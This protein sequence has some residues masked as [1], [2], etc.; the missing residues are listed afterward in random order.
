MNELI[1]QYIQNNPQIGAT[2]SGLLAAD[3]A[4]EPN[5]LILLKNP[6]FAPFIGEFKHNIHLN[7]AHI[8]RC[9]KLL[10]RKNL[11]A[12]IGSDKDAFNIFRDYARWD[13]D[14]TFGIAEEMLEDPITAEIVKSNPKLL[15]KTALNR[16]LD[17]TAIDNMMHF[18]P[19]LAALFVNLILNGNQPSGYVQKKNIA[20]RKGSLA[21]QFAHA[22]KRSQPY[23]N[24]VNQIYPLPDL[25]KEDSLKQYKEIGLKS[26]YFRAEEIKLDET[27]PL[28]IKK[29]AMEGGIREIVIFC[30]KAQ[31]NLSS[32]EFNTFLREHQ[33]AINLKIAP[34]S[35][36]DLEQ[37][38]KD[39]VAKNDLLG[40]NK[41][42]NFTFVYKD[43]HRVELLNSRESDA[44]IIANHL[45]YRRLSAEKYK[46]APPEPQYIREN[47]DESQERR[48][49]DPS[50]ASRHLSIGVEVQSS[51]TTDVDVDVDTSMEVALEHE[52]QHELELDKDELRNLYS[53]L[54]AIDEARYA[55]KE[56]FYDN[57]I[58]GD[59]TRS[60]MGLV[61]N[62]IFDSDD[63]IKYISGKALKF[64]IR[65]DHLFADG[66][67]PDNMPIGMT[68]HEGNLVMSAKRH[69]S[70]QINK[71]TI[72][73]DDEINPIISHPLQYSWLQFASK[74]SLS[75]AD[76]YMTDLAPF[77]LPFLSHPMLQNHRLLGQTDTML[78][79]PAVLNQVEYS[80]DQHMGDIHSSMKIPYSMKLED[81]GVNGISLSDAEQAT[82]TAIKYALT[83]RNF[84]KPFSFIL[85]GMPSNDRG[86]L[87]EEKTSLFF[88]KL[89]E[90]VLPLADKE[91][92]SF[93]RDI[94]GSNILS[95]TSLV[96][97]FEGLDGFYDKFQQFLIDQEIEGDDR[98]EIQSK[99]IQVI[100][101]QLYNI[102][103]FKTSLSRLYKILQ[104]TT[105]IGGSLQEQLSYLTS[106]DNRVSIGDPKI[107]PRATKIG[108]NV[109]NKYAKLSEVD[110]A[111]DLPDEK[112]FLRKLR[113]LHYS[114]TDPKQLEDALKESA[115]VL[116]AVPPQQRASIDGSFAYFKKIYISLP[117]A[118]VI[119]GNLL[120]DTERLGSSPFKTVDYVSQEKLDE[121][122]YDLIV[123]ADHNHW[124]LKALLSMSSKTYTE[125]PI[126]TSGI[127]GEGVNLIEHFTAKQAQENIKLLLLNTLS[128][129]GKH[130]QQIYPNQEFDSYL[131]L[132]SALFSDV[133]IHEKVKT[134]EIYYSAHKDFNRGV[135]YIKQNFS[136]ASIPKHITQKE[137]THKKTVDNFI[138]LYADNPEFNFG[139]VVALG[140]VKNLHPVKFK[141]VVA[142]AKILKQYPYHFGQALRVILSADAPQTSNKI[143]VLRHKGLSVARTMNFLLTEHNGIK[144]HELVTNGGHNPEN[145]VLFA[146]VFAE[147]QDITPEEIRTFIAK[148]DKLDESLKD[149]LLDGL[150]HSKLPFANS[151]FIQNRFPQISMDMLDDP[152]ALNNVITQAK[153]SRISYEYLAQFNDISLNVREN[154][155]IDLTGV[156]SKH[157]IKFPKEIEGKG[158]K[159]IKNYII[160]NQDFVKS[161]LLGNQ[162]DKE[163]IA[164]IS[165][166][167]VYA[168]FAGVAKRTEDWESITAKT[169][170]LLYDESKNLGEQFTTL[171]ANKH[172]IDALSRKTD[173]NNL[174]SSFLTEPKING[175]KLSATL[176]F[177][178]GLDAGALASK[179]IT[180]EGLVQAAGN[181]LINNYFDGFRVSVDIM[182]TSKNKIDIK[183]I[184]QKINNLTAHK[185]K[186]RHINK[187]MGYCIGNDN[188]KIADI[189][190]GLNVKE[191]NIDKVI[192]F[193]TGMSMS[194]MEK[195]SDSLGNNI[196][197]VM[198]LKDISKIPI[199]AEITIKLGDLI[200]KEQYGLMVKQ[201]EEND[202]ANAKLLKSYL[203]AFNPDDLNAQDEK[204]R[205][206]NRE[207]RKNII[208]TVFDNID[209][210][211]RAQVIFSEYNLER[212][213]YSDER[214]KKIINQV[215]RLNT[216]DRSPMPQNQQ[217]LMFD[218]F[219][220]AMSHAKNYSKMDVNEVEKEA[221]SLKH[222]R[223]LMNQ[224]R[225]DE[226]R[227]IDSKFLGLSLEM[228]YRNTSK[229]P[230]DVQITSVLTTMEHKGNVLQQIATGQGKGLISALSASYFSYLGKTPDV[231]TA[232]R[233]LARRDLKEFSQFYDSLAIKHCKKIITADSDVDE[234]KHGEVHV[235]VAS[236]LALFISNRDFHSQSANLAVQP[237]AV[238]IA[239]EFDFVA[240]SEVNFKLAMSLI[241][242]SQEEARVLLKH[243]LE[244]SES[245][246]F[247]NNKVS[248][249]DDVSNLRLYIN[250]RFQ[251]Y[252][253]A[254][255][256]PLTLLQVD[257]LK[258]S[259]D[260]EAQMLYLVNNALSKSDK[261]W[262]YMFDKLLDSAVSVKGLTKDVDFVL[263]EESLADT[264]KLITATPIIKNQPSRGTIYADGVQ[265]ILNM[266]EED[267]NNELKGRFDISLPQST[268]FDLTPK[269]F[270]DY[271]SRVLGI[272]GTAGNTEELEELR[273]TTKVTSYALPMF[274]EDKKIVV[275]Q[276]VE[277]KKL[278]TAHMLKLVKESESERPIITFCESPK[279]AEKLF[280]DIAGL[281]LNIQL[282]LPSA[283]KEEIER[284]VAVAGSAG[285]ITITTGMLGRG[286]DFFTQ[287]E[288]GF[289]GINL[290]TDITLN[291][292]GQIEGRVARNGH[293]GTVVSLF[294]KKQFG[295]DRIEHM[296]EISREQKRKREKSQPASDVA[297][298]M[299]KQLQDQEEEA[300]K[301]N[302]FIKDKWAELDVENRKLP[303]SMQRSYLELR[304]DLTELL[305]V[306]YPKLTGKLDEYLKELDA[307]V[308]KKTGEMTC[309]FKQ[310]W[311]ADYAVTNGWNY[312]L[313]LPTTPSVEVARFVAIS[314][315]P[316]PLTILEKPQY[317]RYIQ[318]NYAVMAGHVWGL[319]EKKIRLSSDASKTKSIFS[320]IA[321][322][323][324][325]GS[326]EDVIIIETEGSNGTLMAD[327]FKSSF[328]AY[329]KHEQSVEIDKINNIIGNMRDIEHSDLSKLEFGKFIALKITT[330]FSSEASHAELLLTDGN[331][332]LWANRGGDGE[333]GKPG[334][335]VFKIV[336]KDIE[337]IKRTLESLKKPQTQQLTRKLIYSNLLWS[338]DPKHIHIDMSAQRVGNCG[339]MQSKTLVRAAAIVGKIDTEAAQLPDEKDKKWLTALNY[340]NKIYRD[341]VQ[342]DKIQRLEAILFSKDEKFATEFL[343][344]DQKDEINKRRKFITEPI[345]PDLL[346]SLVKQLEREVTVG[347][348]ETTVYREQA[349][350]M[351]DILKVYEAME[352]KMGLALY[353]EI[354]KEKTRELLTQYQATH[355]KNFKDLEGVYDA[356]LEKA[357][358][359]GSPRSHAYVFNKV[360]GYL[361]KNTDQIN[362]IDEFIENLAETSKI[363][364]DHSLATKPLMQ[365][366]PLPENIVFPM[367]P[368]TDY[369]G[370]IDLG[371]INIYDSGLLGLNY[372]SSISAPDATTYIPTYTTNIAD[373]FQVPDAT[374]YIPTYT[375]NITDTFHLG[376]VLFHWSKQAVNQL[377]D[378]TI[379][380]FSEDI[381]AKVAL[382]KLKTFDQEHKYLHEALTTLND[383][384]T[385]LYARK[386]TIH[387]DKANTTVREEIDELKRFKDAIAK[388]KEDLRKVKSEIA[389]LV[390]LQQPTFKSVYI[391]RINSY[392]A[393][394]HE[395]H[396]AL[397]DDIA[398]SKEGYNCIVMDSKSAALSATLTKKDIAL[399]L[400]EGILM[401]K[402]K[403]G[404]PIKLNK[405]LVDITLY[406]KIVHHVNNPS[407]TS[408]SFVDDGNVGIAVALS[409]SL[410]FVVNERM[411]MREHLLRRVGIFTTKLDTSR[412]LSS[413][414][415]FCKS[416]N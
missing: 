79:L 346:R 290:C 23:I 70:M 268:I 119:D 292:L 214:V 160:C 150:A 51:T 414:S 163:K 135:V 172:F 153:S 328:D 278:Q 196:N 116:S 241:D 84:Y 376:R 327:E 14:K 341:F 177:L 334:I 304:G 392:M 87:F 404:A 124:K 365:V 250:Y 301:N 86:F 277:N 149:E 112:E 132:F 136:P 398:V 143:D 158:Y 137:E 284:K 37:I 218:S 89:F 283:P 221:I 151:K 193:L 309:E 155:A 347:S 371:Q 258:R 201:I 98:V 81:F 242:I 4:L 61:I 101:A 182:I 16:L 373:T 279:D 313:T 249:K 166:D 205:E 56:I 369:V 165:H 8:N 190:S 35:A 343:N 113:G 406:N 312:G 305:K 67:D 102:G 106:V 281:R 178:N 105:S 152:Q 230:R 209:K 282:I 286:T 50:L 326:S 78:D 380:L 240:L 331:I 378:A 48:I 211:R 30:D 170:S 108:A 364:I 323:M 228:M 366:R 123:K 71:F 276:E 320:Q 352:S 21:E 307:C 264:G 76:M 207:I 379:Q 318:A 63:R 390:K 349:S 141:E 213:N 311:N 333:S 129:S 361:N 187:I 3:P 146:S 399:Y 263:L 252:N 33:I 254:Y 167:I 372:N 191:K 200:T 55:V 210:P 401:G 212:F 202:F 69:P 267:N 405:A 308:P 117:D 31:S 83:E 294:N 215:I 280:A 226:I 270:I 126:S 139:E 356:V 324:G 332:L 43:G 261:H 412:K 367:R 224:A 396:K 310:N 289:L 183:H 164:S 316:L 325:Y 100:K 236:D 293:E 370:G 115:Q 415:K 7:D 13:N 344:S 297:Q 156:A 66:I 299:I 62:K 225:P 140:L 26:L 255:K 350:K 266:Q 243:V 395:E 20:A 1:E 410:P 265:S 338:I 375:A 306:R 64:I 374:T 42:E 220:A 148:V 40:I 368:V 393:G 73:K 169:V 94:I 52:Q 45:E 18:V 138:I 10:K 110:L 303:R 285:Y 272:T 219:K 239:D 127:I 383:E 199:I 104:H 381:D 68:I 134:G 121:E 203:L 2:I 354:G 275:H 12:Y 120:Y 29:L 222:Q 122:E 28:D 25:L 402:A 57:D 171:N 382:K 85:D 162:D 247:K 321:E 9:L 175:D 147:E 97:R 217:D 360:V 75:L 27:S 44:I 6:E 223:M 237:D 41:I 413:S 329:R 269:S 385:E 161:K 288:A 118:D 298:Y 95:P 107:F 130:Y 391:E 197:R 80:V 154:S 142:N 387:N 144:I 176:R 253:S 72:N 287:Y 192:D 180:I 216:D 53:R 74:G 54:Y 128:S 262:D 256:L 355:F 114:R 111:R 345:V 248:K 11:R 188:Y 96:D 49:K 359:D 389:N 208:A 90:E 238:L 227:A 181:H 59:I 39:S 77:V 91:K 5:I 336:E 125:F 231:T 194:D 337:V 408:F 195:L 322:T 259:K 189:L 339:W 174:L 185:Y 353:G 295:S 22:K 335:K 204:T 109:I 93:F 82:I 409:L 159:K 179:D 296:I 60:N 317:E 99:I 103:R 348:Y 394:I 377:H 246:V 168:M 88:N 302:E 300:I 330:L 315:M 46:F 234:Y 232:N 244:F 186:T 235:S 388:I 314:K 233:D 15:L 342:F 19:V 384:I 32:T 274:E 362:S 133:K 38:H 400:D 363:I 17:D 291:D 198:Q 65:H 416:S 229:F 131:S 24:L 340:S 58:K 273:T 351:L 47:D 92:I 319:E 357:I 184:F 386:V 271:Y 245:D 397:L 145:L 257:S 34:V 206:R 358:P 403:D 157:G 251:R 36:H 260:P 173:I 411:E 407:K